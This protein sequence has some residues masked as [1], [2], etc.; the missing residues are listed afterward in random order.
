[1]S[2][3]LS[4]ACGLFA[5]LVV[6]SG[7]AVLAQNEPGV[8]PGSGNSTV[9]QPATAPTGQNTVV[10]TP[11]SAGKPLSGAPGVSAAENTTADANQVVCK[12]VAATTGSRLGGRE[13]CRT[14]EA[15]RERQR[16]SQDITRKLEITQFACV[17]PCR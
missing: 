1:M 7:S 5:L 16:E 12:A 11:Q 15:W 14:Q 6:T 9:A 13:E 17:P 2:T 8:T 4:M 10:V 3:R